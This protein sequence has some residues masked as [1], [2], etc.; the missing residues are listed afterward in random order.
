MR[1]NTSETKAA[2]NYS[3]LLHLKTLK[4]ASIRKNQFAG[5]RRRAYY[6]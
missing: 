2:N 6:V 5:N 1:T 3:N 4:A